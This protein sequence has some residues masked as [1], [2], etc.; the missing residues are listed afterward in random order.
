MTKSIRQKQPGEPL[1]DFR[2]V[3]VML[4]ILLGVNLLALVAALVQ[5]EGIGGILQRFIDMAVWVQPLLLAN[6]ALLASSA[7]L[8]Q[9]L[10]V[11]L[12]KLLVVVLAGGSALILL[13]FWSLLGL[14]ST[15]WQQAT[16]AA[17]LASI[18][19]A[20]LLSYLKLRS[21]ALSPALVEA[22]LQSLTARIRPHFLFNSLNAVV[23]LIRQ[24]PRRAETALEELAELFRALMHDPR[25]LISLADELALCRQ[26]LDLEKLRLGE[27]LGVEWQ[28]EDLP[29][30]V[31]VPPLIVQPLIENAVYHGIETLPSGGTIRISLHRHGDQLHVELSNPLVANAEHQRGNHMALENIRERLALYYD[32]EARLDTAE[33]TR[34]DGRDEYSVHIVL[35]CRDPRR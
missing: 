14:D 6:L 1:P 24:D 26:Y 33:E 4:R 20:A 23:S 25:E 22:R 28:V 7:G 12:A 10:P 9:G 17:L 19:A 13:E 11:W 8:L 32:L 2:N 21:S 3:G 15:G 34:A 18:T 5:S 29:E 35:P 27:R 16:R 30:R 31:R